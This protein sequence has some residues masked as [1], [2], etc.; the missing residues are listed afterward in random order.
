M[1][2]VLKSSMPVVLISPVA[3]VVTNLPR[4]MAQSISGSKAAPPVP[5][6]QPTAAGSFTTEPLGARKVMSP[7]P[8]T[9]MPAAS[10]MS[11]SS[12]V[13]VTAPPSAVVVRMSAFR[14]RVMVPPAPPAYRF[15]EPAPAFSTALMSAS[16]AKSTERAALVVMAPFK[17]EIAT[18]PAPC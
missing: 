9:R 5:A 14:P 13:S 11:P 2:E 3:G 8:A 6:F 15:T 18:L 4:R 1:R 16:M 7:A 12:A 10:V 17:V